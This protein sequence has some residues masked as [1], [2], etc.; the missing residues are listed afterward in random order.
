MSTSAEGS[1]WPCV[2]DCAEWN[3]VSYPLAIKQC[4]QWSTHLHGMKLCIECENLGIRAVTATGP[5][6]ADLIISWHQHL[7]SQSA[8][9]SG[10]G[11]RR[12]VWISSWGFLLL[13]LL[14]YA[15]VV[16][17][18]YLTSAD[19]FL[20]LGGG[21]RF[22]YAMLVAICLTLLSMFLPGKER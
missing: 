8:T 19:A 9:T 13:G 1:S 16:E 3:A 14:G 12:V 15:G 21:W 7:S 10:T 6:R 4:E 18:P 2:Q 17:V 11:I 20:Y 22:N 5:S